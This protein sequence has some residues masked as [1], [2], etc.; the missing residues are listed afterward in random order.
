MAYLNIYNSVD[1]NRRSI[2]LMR[3]FNKTAIACSVLV[4][5]SACGGG[6]SETDP[7]AG[8]DT[9]VQ[10]KAKPLEA[11]P[12]TGTAEGDTINIT[13]KHVLFFFPSTQ[14]A[15]SMNLDERD[16]TR[17]KS[18]AQSVIDS[19]GVISPGATASLTD[20]NHVRVYGRKGFPMIIS[21]TSFSD[22]FGM[23]ISD[24]TQMAPITKG[25]RSRE[26]YIEQIRRVLNFETVQAPS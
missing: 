26:A 19:I 1:C 3:V 13:G 10:A 17:F 8:S 2:A 21:L 14:K 4:L 5:I 12:A 7:K 16:I 18:T 9:T 23:V 20:L 24:G 25:L 11:I 15:K 22:A 6:T